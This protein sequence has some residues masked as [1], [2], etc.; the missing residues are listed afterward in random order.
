M[1]IRTSA[2]ACTLA[3]LLLS[4]APLSPALLAKDPSTMIVGDTTTTPAASPVKYPE[5][6]EAVIVMKAKE[7]GDKEMTMTVYKL[8]DHQRVE[9]TAMGQNMIT[10]VD[11]KSQKATT[12]IPSQKLATIMGLN[13]A[14][15]PLDLSQLNS[16][17]NGASYKEVARE[18]IGDVDTIKY[19]VSDAD[20]KKSADLWASTTTQYPVK[21][22][23]SNGQTTLVWKSLVDTKPDAALFEVP[24]D[25]KVMDMGNL[26]PAMLNGLKGLLK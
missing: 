24:K 9:M 21:L 1:K 15:M 19:E 3:A 16:E 11:A 4:L 6:F 26:D 2:T 17:V 25:Y 8:G 13:S 12:L 5:D 23:P 14:T 7:L 20:G 18:K 10:L 22:A